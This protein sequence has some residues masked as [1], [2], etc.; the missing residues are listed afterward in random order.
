MTPTLRRLNDRERYYGLT[1]P[2]W[3]ALAAAGGVLYG[4]V[5]VSPFG[6]RATVTVVVLVLA[7]LASIALALQGQ[8][9]GP[10]RYLLALYRYRRATKQLGAA[11]GS[12]TSSGSSSTSHRTRRQSPSR[13]STGRRHD[14]LARRPAPDLGARARRSDRHH[15]RVGTCG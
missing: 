11:D 14:R 7:F 13:F 1:W 4:A 5:R 15:R 12:R 10:G 3:V 6:L 8:T 9:I 2:G